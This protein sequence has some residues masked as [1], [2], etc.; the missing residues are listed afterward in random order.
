LPEHSAVFN[1]SVRAM[2]LLPLLDS[3][4][5]LE[6]AVA[7]RLRELLSVPILDLDALTEAID[8]ESRQVL[9]PESASPTPQ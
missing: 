1:N 4:A 2:R 3:Y 7:P 9:A 8:E 6:G 5:E